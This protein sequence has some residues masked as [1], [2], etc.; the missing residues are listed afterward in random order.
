MLTASMRN[1]V[2]L[3][4][5]L[6]TLWGL[7]ASC[8]GCQRQHPLKDEFSQVVLRRQSQAADLPG[9]GDEEAFR[10]FVRRHGRDA[11]PMYRAVISA[12]RLSLIHI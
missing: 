12:V 11:V 5:R 9:D 1:G 3:M 2:V 8:V 10:G 7:V 6:G 4:V